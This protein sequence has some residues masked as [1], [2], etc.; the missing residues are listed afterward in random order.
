MAIKSLISKFNNEKKD[1]YSILE[2]SGANQLNEIANYRDKLDKSIKLLN[3]VS[4]ES[5]NHLKRIF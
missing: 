4:E 3:E 2:R 5:I 1:Q